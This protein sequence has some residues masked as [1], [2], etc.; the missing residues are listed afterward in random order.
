[1]ALNIGIFFQKIFFLLILDTSLN[2]SLAMDHLSPYILRHSMKTIPLNGSGKRVPVGKIL[3]L[4][5]NYADHTLEMKATIP[6]VPVVF[7]K[8]SSALIANGEAIVRPPVSKELHHEVEL[9]V[10][11]GKEGKNIPAARAYEYVWGYAVGLDM[12]L[13][14]LQS[15]AKNQ[16]LPWSVAKGFDTSAAI[17]EIIPKERISDPHSLEIR[18]IVNGTLRQKSSTGKM[19]FTIDRIIEYLSTIFTLE[20]GDLIFTGTPEGVGEVKEADVVEAELVGYARTR[21]QIHTAQM[22]M[23]RTVFTRVAFLSCLLLL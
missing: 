23:A 19:I 13:R 2:D 5:R 10:V 21:H 17:S 20:V 15:T 12:T 11:I 8:P 6:E 18:C 4:G 9:V 22:M 1:M 16:G 7:L 14:D 3:C